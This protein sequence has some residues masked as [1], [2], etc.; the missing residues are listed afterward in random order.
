MD[1]E[2]LQAS[3][4]LA[5][6][7]G[8]V[9]TAKPLLERLLGPAFDYAGNS[10]LE[11]LRRYGNRNLTEIFRRA[12]KKREDSSPVAGVNPRVLRAVIEDGGLANDEI[13]R[14]YYAGLLESSMRGGNEDDRAVTFLSI[15]RALS[16]RQISLHH[17]IYS[18]IR[19]LYTSSNCSFRIGRPP[20]RL[21]ADMAFK[22]A[23]LPTV[24]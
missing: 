11:L 3:E 5:A 6:T 14:E 21:I 2:L 15:I 4:T 23:G 13:T 8:G 19:S 22:E 18:C 7:I 17:F 12:A 9:L 1:A 20:E 24:R 16:A 10:L